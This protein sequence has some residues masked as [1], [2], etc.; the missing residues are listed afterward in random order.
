MA[1][2]LIQG[3]QEE[4]GKLLRLLKDK[5]SSVKKATSFNNE[6]GITTI[7]EVFSDIHYTGDFSDSDVL[8]ALYA[9]TCKEKRCSECPYLRVKDCEKQLQIDSAVVIGRMHG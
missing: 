9:C 4:N 6:Q 3:T 2:I 7:Y 5:F 1:T 8:K